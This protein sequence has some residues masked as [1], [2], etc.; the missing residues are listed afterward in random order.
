MEVLDSQTMWEDPT[1]RARFSEETQAKGAPDRLLA[2]TTDKLLH[3]LSVAQ[4]AAVDGTHRITPKQFS[5]TFLMMMKMG[6]KWL[7][8]VLGL[9]PSHESEAYSLYMKM[10][11]HTMESKGL[12]FK[13]TSILSDFEVGIQQ[14]IQECFPGVEIRGCRSICVCFCI[15]ELHCFVVLLVCIC[16]PHC[17]CKMDGQNLNRKV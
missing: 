13:L 2:F 4:K 16:L 7:P 11:I 9:L 1:F 8:S 5:Q 15:C 14:A 17:S 6:D 12:G 3:Q 10:I